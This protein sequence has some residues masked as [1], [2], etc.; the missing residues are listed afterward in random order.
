M[1][2]PMSKLENKPHTKSLRAILLG[3]T[4]RNQKKI[5]EN[6]EKQNKFAE[7]GYTA[8]LQNSDLTKPWR[9]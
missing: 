4:K 7:N 1:Y 2:V 5:C 6:Y 9:Q 8:N 3:E